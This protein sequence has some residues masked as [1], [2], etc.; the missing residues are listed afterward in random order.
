MKW[1]K[2]SNTVEGKKKFG[3]QTII[4]MG[5]AGLRKLRS[6]EGLGSRNTRVAGKIR[7]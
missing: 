7:E 1:M 3:F 6:R 4:L 5:G 2:I